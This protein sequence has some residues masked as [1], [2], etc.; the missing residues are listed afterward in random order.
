MYLFIFISTFIYVLCIICILFDIYAIFVLHSA[1]A[2]KHKRVMGHLIHPFVKR[3]M[4][5][6]VFTFGEEVVCCCV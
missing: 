6:G 3:C 5:W 1:A 2:E 4:I